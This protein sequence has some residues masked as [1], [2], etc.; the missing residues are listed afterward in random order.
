MLPLLLVS[1]PSPLDLPV[2]HP[3][4]TKLLVQ[5][6]YE[7]NCLPPYHL[8]ENHDGILGVVD[9]TPLVMALFALPR[10]TSVQDLE[11]KEISS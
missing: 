8:Y 9:A 10:L 6:A 7:L 2:Y 3:G 5:D 4:H 11:T 1:F